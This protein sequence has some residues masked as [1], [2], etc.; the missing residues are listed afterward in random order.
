M[1][2]LYQR[3]KKGIWW[4][5]YSRDGRTYFESARTTKKKEAGDLLRRREGDI[6][7]GVPV[8]SKVGRLRFEEAAE[9]LLNDYTSECPQ[10]S[11]RRRA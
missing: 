11:Q 4:I 3:G 1:G 9:D 5:K 8:S 2:H 10:V 6:A 7:R